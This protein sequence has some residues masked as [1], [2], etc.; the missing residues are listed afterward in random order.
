MEAWKAL[1]CRAE[2]RQTGVKNT[3]RHKTDT[4]TYSYTGATHTHSLSQTRYLSDIKQVD[5]QEEC[6]GAGSHLLGRATDGETQ[7][8]A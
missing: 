1:I 4:L 3:C 6:R 2:Q 7:L 5:L 8:T